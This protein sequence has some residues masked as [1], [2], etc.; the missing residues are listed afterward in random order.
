VAAGIE[1]HVSYHVAA[2]KGERLLARAAET[3]R[4]PRLATY[5]IDVLRRDERV[6]SFTG[7]VYVTGRH[8]G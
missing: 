6:A 5:R 3:S 8:H 7:T 2:R 4:T 1:A